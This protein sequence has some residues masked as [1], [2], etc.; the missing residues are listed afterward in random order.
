MQV[1]SRCH[2]ANPREAVFCHYDGVYLAQGNG[3]PGAPPRGELPQEFVFPSGRRC[4]TFDDLV[5]GC[6][7]DW[8]D[9]RGLLRRGDFGQFFARIGRF[10]LTRAAQEA[11]NQPDPDIALH[12][13]VEQLPANQVQGPRLDLEPRRLLLGSVHA[14]DQRPARLTL[15]NQGKGILQ[16]KV[17]V[18]EGAQ[19]LKIAEG[20][21]DR[22][23][24]VK[25]P[26]EQS[27]ALR[28]DTRG[29]TAPQSYSAR[30][31]VITNGGIAEVPVRLDVAAVAF[32]RPPFQGATSP[33]A[34]AERMRRNPKQAVPLLESSEIAR[35][36]AVNG[37]TYPVVG[38]TARGIAA[39]QQ[40]FECMGLSRPPPL[41]LSDQELR[42]QCTPP[43]VV[44]GQVSLRTASKKWV[45]AQADSNVTWL[46]ITTPSVSGPQH[47]AIAFEIDS[48]LLEEGR[49]HEGQVQ[50]LANAGQRLGFRVRVE[51]GRTKKSFV[52]M[53]AAP[54]ASSRPAPPREAV[55]APPPA[56]PSAWYTPAPAPAAP[57]PASPYPAAIPEKFAPG[58]LRPLVVGALLALLF[59]LV[60][61][62][63]ADLFARVLAAG[64]GPPRSGSL[65]TWLHTPGTEDG[66]LK[67]FV[68]A[69]WWVGGFVGVRLAW[70]KG[71]NM[72]DLFC[73]IVAGAGAGLIAS[74]SAGCALIAVDSLPR[75]LLRGL[76]SGTG[77]HTSPWLWTPVWVLLASL[78]WAVL[79]GAAGL[80]LGG[81]GRRG[82]RLLAALAA[83]VS[84][85]FRL[86]GMGKA[87][88]F[89]ALEG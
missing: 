85:M 27:V 25:A 86:C 17:A 24:A 30:L 21:N 31:T 55:A 7:Y 41:T 18:T 82:L 20:D 59:R 8:E 40:F 46:R 74:A 26:R 32:S 80:V 28:I 52:Q 9:A 87:A 89:F 49:A 1:C 71:G 12:N 88:G 37:W 54:F 65:A 23:C 3:A 11:Q 10:D 68:L 4:R 47:A 64:A 81:L 75:A 79:G 44:R 14:G 58:L 72:A 51:V 56:P 63:P 73:A 36:F 60:L 48:S 33:R 69:T 78:Y 35:W 39:V 6:Q 77:D 57:R 43:E 2:R 16:G 76:A 22:N 19:W 45:Y 67:L 53:M 29:L 42:F 50:V 84:G 34:L 61:A 38:A 83:P 5:Q 70:R 15:V 66:F 13:F 62:V